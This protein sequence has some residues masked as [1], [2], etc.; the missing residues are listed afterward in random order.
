LGGDVAEGRQHREI[1]RQLW[2]AQP[3]IAALQI[4]AWNIAML[5][6]D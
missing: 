3:S 2:P 1:G 4:F 5:A 6:V